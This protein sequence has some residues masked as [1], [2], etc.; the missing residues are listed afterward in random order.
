MIDAFLAL[1][2]IMVGGVFLTAIWVGFFAL[3]YSITRFLLEK[4]QSR[5]PR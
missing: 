3:I 5:S 2:V 4:W 1:S